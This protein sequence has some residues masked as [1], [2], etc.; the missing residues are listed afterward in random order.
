M[1]SDK[2][3]NVNEIDTNP[4]TFYDFPTASKGPVSAEKIIFF[5][6]STAYKY[7]SYLLEAVWDEDVTDI[8]K[9]LSYILI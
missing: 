8:D 9:K 3:K 2:N 6:I 4:N 1:E 5:R 7:L